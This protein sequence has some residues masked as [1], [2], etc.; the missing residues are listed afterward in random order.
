MNRIDLEFGGIEDPI[1]HFKATSNAIKE[2]LGTNDPDNEMLP[3]GFFT[4]VVWR[5]KNRKKLHFYSS[6]LSVSFDHI[7]RELCNEIHARQLKGLLTFDILTEWVSGQGQ[8]VAIAKEHFGLMRPNCLRRRVEDNRVCNKCEFIRHSATRILKTHSVSPVD[9]LEAS[10]FWSVQNLGKICSARFME[11]C[12]K[13]GATNLEF[14]RLNSED[15][16][17]IL[18]CDEWY[19]LCA[20]CDFN[21]RMWFKKEP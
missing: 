10:D 11:L 8:P 5:T 9:V 1:E 2:S 14:A 15:I 19:Q 13:L 21:K 16:V 6:P 4:P 18:S 20:I 12:V 17:K 7:S 3:G